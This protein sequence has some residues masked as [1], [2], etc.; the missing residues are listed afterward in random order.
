[1]KKIVSLF[2]VML[3]VFS[4][5]QMDP[6]EEAKKQNNDEV[7]YSGAID[8][9]TWEIRYTKHE[10]D[11]IISEVVNYIL[12]ES[13]TGKKVGIAVNKEGTSEDNSV[14]KFAIM[15]GRKSEPFT[16]EFWD[17]YSINLGQSSML[18][19]NAVST[20]GQ[21]DDYYL[22]VMVGGINRDKLQ[23]L[24]AATAISVELQSTTDESRITRIPVH[25]NFQK[26]L[27]SK[28]P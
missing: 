26:A 2:F 3:L 19:N 21:E 5:C 10:K 28:L 25:P 7:L 17:R 16:S 14:Y 27:L 12:T 24:K 1:M 9:G 22:F 18:M 4:S 8:G 6:K 23:Q 11:G 13:S 15:A 20:P